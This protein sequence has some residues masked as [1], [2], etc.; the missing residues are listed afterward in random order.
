MLIVGWNYKTQRK[1]M[2]ACDSTPAMCLRW[3]SLAIYF[4]W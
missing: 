1:T 4:F 3:N 2:A